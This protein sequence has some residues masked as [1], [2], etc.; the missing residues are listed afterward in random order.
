MADQHC[1]VCGDAQHISHLTDAYDCLKCGARMDYNG[2][3]L[4]GS[5][6][7]EFGPIERIIDVPAS[8]AKKS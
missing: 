1:G 5:S 6:V 4:R 2:E 7:A 8:K 3:V